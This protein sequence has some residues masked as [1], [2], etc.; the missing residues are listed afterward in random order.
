MLALLT[1]Q[2]VQ[3]LGMSARQDPVSLGYDERGS[4][5]TLYISDD[6]TGASDNH[7]GLWKLPC[8]QLACV[9]LSEYVQQRGFDS[10]PGVC[11]AFALQPESLCEHIDSNP[12]V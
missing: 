2:H 7:Q 3:L 11:S 12:M 4:A 9:G 5:K 6:P 8:T 10:R 1:V